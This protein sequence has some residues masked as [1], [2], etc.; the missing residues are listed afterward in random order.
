[1]YSCQTQR[2]GGVLWKHWWAAVS[3]QIMTV[4]HRNG[5]QMP[6]RHQ[7]VCVRSR[8]SLSW[9][10]VISPVWDRVLPWCVILEVG[11]RFWFQ[12]KASE[13]LAYV[14]ALPP[15][16][17]KRYLLQSTL[18]FIHLAISINMPYGPDHFTLNSQS[19]TPL[20]GLFTTTHCDPSL[21]WGTWGGYSRH[22]V[23]HTSQEPHTR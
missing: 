10:A 19:W 16:I 3:I 13:A 12:N 5:Q 2:R 17:P 6:C 4:K 1:M 9:C 23:Q 8:L 7:F 18:Y 20:W 22:V 15:L 21:R 14:L 11:T